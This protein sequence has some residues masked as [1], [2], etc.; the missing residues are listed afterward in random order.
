VT[1]KPNEVQTIYN[2]SDSDYKGLS[3]N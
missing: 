2:I 3:G 1:L